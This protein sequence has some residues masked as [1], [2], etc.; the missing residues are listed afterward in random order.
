MFRR[1]LPTLLCVAILPTCVFAADKDL[2]NDVK[3][4]QKI[5][6]QRVEKEFADER[7]SAY[8]LV[9]AATP[10]L[11]KAT[12]KLRSLLAMVE[13]DTSLDPKR[14]QVLIVTLKWDLDRVKEIA[15]QRRG[16]QT[17]T[18]TPKTVVGRDT[19]RTDRDDNVGKGR[20][21]DAKAIMDARRA[22][23]KGDTVDRVSKGDRFTR[24][25]RS[26]DDSAVPESRN[27]VLPKDWL[28]KTRKRSTGIKMTAKERAIM[29]AL[30]KTMGAD[31]S[32][33]KFSE[34]IDYLK[35]AT[36]IDIVID[37]RALDEVNVT[38][39]STINLKARASTRTIIKRIL[40]DLDLAYVI[41]DEAM[42][43]T[44]RER[45]SQMTTT[46]T[47]YIGD[48]ATVVDV[49]VP[50][51]ISQLQA[52]ETV[53]RI[54]SLIKSNVEPRSW[55]DANPDAPGSIYFDPVSMS[56]VVKQTAEVHYMMA[57]K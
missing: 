36:G 38:Y 39:E 15:G 34:V 10:D 23:I 9:R 54:I 22:A 52:I 45:A 55:K 18:P 3:N 27:Y 28:E 16:T 32:N 44:S 42:L 56:L 19:P 37:K 47:Y 26:V 33:D 35:K 21:S 2:L 57:G 30:G 40:A 5:E 4:R 14:R 46:R 43:I 51:I 6:A 31:F 53:N 17:Y 20:V 41:K 29:T 48:L 1:W 8:Q 11:N 7:A 49:R 25:M 12:E 13:N 24:V 50:F